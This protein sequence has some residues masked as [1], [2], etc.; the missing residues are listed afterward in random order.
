MN[1]FS[2]PKMVTQL[3]WKC[4]PDR[5]TLSLWGDK[6]DA[7]TPTKPG[8]RTNRYSLWAQAV[9][10]L[11]TALWSHT[12]SA[13]SFSGDAITYFKM[14]I[15]GSW[16]GPYR[17]QP[18]MFL[19]LSLVRPQ[20]F[21]A[22]LFWSG[23]I[24]LTLLLVAFYRLNYSRID[25]LL[26][27]VFFSCSFYGVH[28]L[29][30]FQRQFYA[31]AFFLLAI[32]MKRGSFLV[33]I[34]SLLSHTFA[35]AAHLF[36]TARKFNA[37]LIIWLLISTIP[38]FYFLA[39]VVDTDK[40]AGYAY[41][42]EDSGSN[43]VIKQS[44]NIIYTLIIVFTLRTGKSHART[45]SYVYIGMCVPC[46]LWPAYG[47]LFARFDYYF[48]PLLIALWPASL[49]TH[50]RTVFRLVLIGSTALG[51]YLWIHMNFAWIINGAA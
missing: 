13:L 8:R 40:V 38:L 31:I 26:L 14:L 16:L 45:L 2:D 34:C 4:F 5:I 7:W 1:I 41:G 21:M 27:T 19:V 50:R 15:D 37:A 23:V 24:P 17:F 30:D 42:G 39:T 32:S 43:I 46:L 25:Q 49:N 35:F 12:V 11:V 44:L 48:F 18:T 3:R 28:F 36:W 29:L 10:L 9:I 22:Y 51:F 6:K 47:R 33:R 20:T